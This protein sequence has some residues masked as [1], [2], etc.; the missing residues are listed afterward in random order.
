MGGEPRVVITRRAE[1]AAVLGDKLSAAGFRPV[2][3]PTIQLQAMAAPELDR[4]LGEVEHF[5]WLLFSSA[6]AVHFFF[7]RLD[8]L[9]LAPRLPRTAVVGSATARKLAEH[10]IQVDFMPA[11]FTG[12]ALAAGLGDV[13]GQRILLPRARI[14]S[15]QIVET[16]RSQGALVT[17]IAL[18]DTVTAV[19]DQAALD[20]LAVGYE[21]ITFASPS[22][23]Q[24]FLE[25]IGK[26]IGPAVVA[27]IGPV[28][29]EAATACGLRVTVMPDEY[30]LDGLV[31]ALTLYFGERNHE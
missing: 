25:I 29:A 10:D 13:A 9:N 17:D 14:G 4:A 19:P 24:G 18:Y 16:L 12:E 31:Q 7:R 1:Q 3:F 30:T 8:E 21:A 15:P 27:C 20:V 22:S 5:E 6:N 26:P 28:T 23:V 11:T 2:Y